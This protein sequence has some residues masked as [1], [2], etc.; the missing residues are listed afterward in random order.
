M[1]QNVLLWIACFSLAFCTCNAVS[2]FKDCADKQLS[3]DKPL[4]CKIRNLQVDGNMPKVKEYMNCAFESSG[5][6][7]DGGKKLDTSKVAQDMVPYGF[8]VKKELDEVT[9][10][11]ETEFGAETSS[12]DYLACLLIDEKTKTQF[13]TMLMMK[14]ADFFKQNLCN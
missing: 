3:G 12:I 8:N 14:E 9:K 11:C 4:Q 13:K 2:H 5:W 6:T 10:E 1:K 7:K